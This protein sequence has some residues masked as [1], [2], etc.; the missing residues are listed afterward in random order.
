MYMKEDLTA[1]DAHRQRAI[2]VCRFLKSLPE[3][4]NMTVCV[5]LSLFLTEKARLERSPL[6]N[7]FLATA[8]RSK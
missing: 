8:K 7:V 3:A 1:H 6:G 5:T 4:R 2:E